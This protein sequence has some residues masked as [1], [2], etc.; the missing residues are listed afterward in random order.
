MPTPRHQ[1]PYLATNQSQKETTHNEALNIMDFASNAYVMEVGLDTPPGS[2]SD[3]DAYIVGT[4]PTGDWE[5]QENCLAFYLSGWNFIAPFLG[6][7]VFD[8]DSNA[9]KIFN[10]TNWINTPSAGGDPYT[11][12]ETIEGD[13]PV[14]TG[15]TAVLMTIPA[16]SIVVAGSIRNT[17]AIT[18]TLTSYDFGTDDGSASRFGGSLGKSLNASNNG[19]I[20]P[21]GFYS[22]TDVILT[23]NGGNFATGTVR[24]RLHLIRTVEPDAV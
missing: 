20:G 6:F 3:G 23:A 10:G 13:Y 15:T 1:L 7:Q 8:F 9:A 18:G 19:I 11:Y 2:P 12:M 21:T 14:G 24:A 5:D 4:S 17:T 16:R 22:D